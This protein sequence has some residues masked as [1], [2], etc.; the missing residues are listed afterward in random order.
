MKNLRF[1]K[2]ENA[3]ELINLFHLAK[4]PLSGGDNSR[5]AR[6]VWA[7][8]EFSKAHPEVSS[9]AAYKDLEVLL[10]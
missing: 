7:S 1:I 8:K 6:M 9:T 10:S 4:V 3:N 5:W 2:Q